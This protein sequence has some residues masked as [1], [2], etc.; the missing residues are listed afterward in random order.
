[1]KSTRL[2]LS[3][4]GA[5]AAIVTAIACSSSSDDGGGT[6]PPIPEGGMLLDDGAVVGPD[7]E[8]ITPDATRPSVVN[9]T[10]AN[11]DGFGARPDYTLAVPKTYDGGKKY[12]LILVFHGDGGT[13]AGMRAAHTLDDTTGDA[14][15]VVYPSGKS[16]TWDLSTAFNDNDDQKYVEALIAAMKAKYSIADSKVFGVGYSSGGFMVNQLSCRRAIFRGI[17]VYAG[18][19]P[20]ELPDNMP[21]DP[22]GYLVCPNSPKVAAFIVHGTADTTVD[23]SS[24]DFDAKFWAHYN[25][26]DPDS[27]SDTTPAPCKKH[28]S[29]PTGE[30]SVFCL[31][32]GLGHTPWDPGLAAEWDFFKGL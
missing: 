32:P 18:G 24:G 14:A 28:A 22:Q 4:L 8:V 13:G 17:S 12:P 16:N 3:V 23:P 25:G 19:A 2:S 31:V 21:Q 7:G 9:V 26:C 30:P 10:T 20:F 1:M 29:C 15:I 11:I 5:A 27:R 6:H